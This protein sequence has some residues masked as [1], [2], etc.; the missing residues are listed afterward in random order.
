LS[1]LDMFSLIEKMVFGEKPKEPQPHNENE[2]I[3]S[4]F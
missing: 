4:N 2:R 1:K 3:Y